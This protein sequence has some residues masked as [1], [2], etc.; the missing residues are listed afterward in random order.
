[1]K[2]RTC[3]KIL[4]LFVYI[5][6]THTSSNI[7]W[8]DDSSLFYLFIVVWF[9]FLQ[10]LGA[11]WSTSEIANMK[12]NV[13]F[14]LCLT[15]CLF[16]ICVGFNMGAWEFGAVAKCLRKSR[17][18]NNPPLL[19]L[20]LSVLKIVYLISLSIIL[21]LVWYHMQNCSSKS[22]PIKS[23]IWT[24]IY[25]SSFHIIWVLELKYILKVVVYVFT[26]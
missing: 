16:L 10:Y 5:F 22:H 8:L 21:C 19:W 13:L 6:Y 4:T 2:Y 14:A 26:V 11:I 12:E 1:M 24:F 9:T 20:Q 23:K 18:W 15:F 3:C 25:C 7:V 17:S